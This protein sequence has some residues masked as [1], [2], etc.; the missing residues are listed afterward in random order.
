MKRVPWLIIAAII[1]AGFAPRLA[2]LAW[3]SHGSLLA[4]W[5]A[6][7]LWLCNGVAPFLPLALFAASWVGLRLS[8]TVVF[9]LSLLTA[10]FGIAV[11]LAAMLF[12]GAGTFILLAQGLCLTLAVIAA[13][14]SLRNAASP[15]VTR[16]LILPTLAAIWSLAMVPLILW[17]A[18]RIAAGAPYC[19]ARNDSA[20]PLTTINDLRGFVFYT[21]AS[22]YK[23]NQHWYLHGVLIVDAPQAPQVYNWSPRALRFDPLPNPE[24]YISLPARACTPQTN[25]IF[26]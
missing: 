12:S 14:Q 7:V 9:A 26:G 22:G 4:G 3:L 2:D 18:D 15:N 8:N 6:V 1:A 19:I 17:Q 23:D 16:M 10:L 5:V 13:L 11:T 20:P 25:G 21:T 24:D